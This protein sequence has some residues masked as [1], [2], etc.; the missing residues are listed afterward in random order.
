MLE[1]EPEGRIERAA[2]ALQIGFAAPFHGMYLGGHIVFW[3]NIVLQLYNYGPISE[4][5]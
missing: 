2:R 4:I 3:S 1:A 5:L